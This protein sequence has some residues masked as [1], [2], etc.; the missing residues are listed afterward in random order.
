MDDFS[1]PND[2][3]SDGYSESRNNYIEGGKRPQSSMSPIIIY[4][5]NT[6][7]VFAV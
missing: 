6:K 4:D 5:T 1:R 7:Q 3:D 2:T